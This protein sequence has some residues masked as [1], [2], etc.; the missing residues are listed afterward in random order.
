MRGSIITF[1]AKGVPTTESRPD[2]AVAVKARLRF[3]HGKFVLNARVSGRSNF[4][5]SASSQRRDGS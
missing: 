3:R 5:S 4:E 2:E 1:F